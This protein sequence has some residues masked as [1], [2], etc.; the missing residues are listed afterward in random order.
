MQ[1]WEYCL[2]GVMREAEKQT[3]WVH[4]A[5]REPE[6]LYGLSLTEMLTS[7]GHEGWELIIEKPLDKSALEELQI[8]RGV[9][10]IFKRP[11]EPSP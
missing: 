8:P 11:I 4:R 5:G 2:L 7:L 10:Y 1:T 9:Q 6:K 3:F